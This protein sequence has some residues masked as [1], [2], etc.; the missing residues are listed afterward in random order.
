MVVRCAITWQPDAL[1]RRDTNTDT[2]DLCDDET[3]YA[4]GD[5]NF[6]TTAV[7]DGTSGSGTFGDVVERYVYDP[8][9]NLTIYLPDWSDTRAASSY[10]WTVLFA[11]YWRDA[12]TGL[13]HVRHRMY[14]VRLGLWLTRD[15]EGYVDGMSLYAYVSVNPL[16]RHDPSG[17][18]WEMSPDRVKYPGDKPTDYAALGAAMGDAAQW[19]YNDLK[20]I[21]PYLETVGTS[22]F[23]TLGSAVVGAVDLADIVLNG[24][25]GRDG[26]VWQQWNDKANEDLP[27]TLH[28]FGNEAGA[29]LDK[30]VRGL[31]RRD[32]KAVGQTLGD[33]C[34]GGLMD[35]G[36]RRAT[37]PGTVF[38]NAKGM[39]KNAARK[40]A[41]ALSS[42]SDDVV[43][44]ISRGRYPQSAAH[45]ESS[46]NAGRPLTLDRAGK[47]ARHAQAVRK[48]PTRSGLDRDVS[49]PVVFKESSRNTSIRYID[50]SDNRGAGATMGHQIRKVPDG[51]RVRITIKD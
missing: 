40:V 50:P 41:K 33:L 46:G 19:T 35:R 23:E 13:Y 2:D 32:P 15:P 3:L 7:V 6:N 26:N 10:D 36:L 9:G 4:L 28:E 43:V 49:P 37:G 27:G 20:G 44:E 11:G 45:L 51:K 29:G 1:L 39:A 5:A 14:H 48:T 47:A 21:P 18:S 38:G 8:Y 12:E 16:G 34:I 25:Y 31:I 30:Q 24:G 17:L 22:F 42:K